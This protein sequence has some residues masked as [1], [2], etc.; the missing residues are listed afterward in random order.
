M[1]TNIVIP[2]AGE[3]SRFSRVGYKKPKPFIDV[4]GKPMIS[5]VLQNLSCLDANYVLIA[6]EDHLKQ[7][8]KLV[9]EIEDKYPV[10]FHPISHLTEGAACTVLH[11]REFINNDDPLIIANSDQIVDINFQSF[12]SDSIERKLDGSLMVF[13][14]ESKDPKWSFA[15]IDENAIVQEVK[16]KEPI[17]NLATVGIYM[18]NE[19]KD[20]VDSAIDMIVN[21]DQVNDEYY[22]CPVYNYA[23]KNNKKF[24]V[25][26]IPFES[27]HGLGTPQDLDIY[28]SKSSNI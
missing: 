26:E 19:G 1:T 15:K 23:I 3:G 10:T 2:M 21:R 9:K 27:M 11:A 17:S 8:P 14:D 5:L 25:F 12:V 18:F 28:L 22:V 6:R 13:I 4:N 16:E 7:E 24:G 20:F